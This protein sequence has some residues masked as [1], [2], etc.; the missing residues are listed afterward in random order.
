MLRPSVAAAGGIKFETTSKESGSGIRPKHGGDVGVR[1]PRR[2][3]SVT[4]HESNASRYIVPSGFAGRTIMC[5]TRAL[6]G[7]SHSRGIY[8]FINGRTRNF[9]CSTDAQ[10]KFA[11]R[12]P[13]STARRSD[14]VRFQLLP[15]CC[16]RAKTR[17]SMAGRPSP[18]ALRP[19]LHLIKLRPITRTPARQ[20]SLMSKRYISISGEMQRASVWNA[21]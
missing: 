20:F 18:L 4:P 17:P 8:H 7:N 6:H 11:P 2:F 9:A 1:E 19:E 13:R 10:M 21:R 15:V 16:A 5:L 3:G 14:R 12:R